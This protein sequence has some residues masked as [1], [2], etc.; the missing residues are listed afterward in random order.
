MLPDAAV[1]QKG[2]PR[3]QPFREKKR[4]DT[5]SFTQSRIES[6]GVDEEDEAEEEVVADKKAL[7][8]ME[9]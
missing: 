6:M 2:I 1:F 5:T 4:F 3:I 7:A 8:E 9:D